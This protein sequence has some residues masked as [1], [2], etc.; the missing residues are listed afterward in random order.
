VKLTA[1]IVDDEMLG[2][3]IIREYLKPHPEIEIIGECRDAH[4]TLAAL[5]KSPVDLMFL[6]I[7]MPEINGFELLE[8]LPE[9]PLVIFSTA[10]DQYAIKAFEVN[11]VDY[12]LKPFDKNRFEM[13]LNRALENLEQR[14]AANF[15]LAQLLHNLPAPN[16][17]DRFLI[18]QA[19]KI[20]ILNCREIAAF[21]AMEDYVNIHTARERFLIQQTMHGLLPKLNPAV[22]IQ[23]HRSFIVNINFI[24]EIET[25][26]SGRM[27]IY[28]KTGAKIGASR[29]GMKRLR[30]LFL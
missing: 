12:L 6:D 13:A 15:K 29:S 18:K 10:Y 3:Q 23:V 14:T 8:M 28:L 25:S 1:L 26:P 22:F 11:A 9:K 27:L 20:V 2:R 16:Y 7:Q 5:E 17:Q 19:G 24:Q 30:E 21:E 4:E